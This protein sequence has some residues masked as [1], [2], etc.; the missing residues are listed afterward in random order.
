MESGVWVGAG[1]VCVWVCGWKG[2][3]ANCFPP[4][5]SETVPWLPG[6]RR[7][8]PR[9]TR[10]MFLATP[11]YHQVLHMETVECA[12]PGLLWSFPRHSTPTGRGGSIED[13]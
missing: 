1:C 5:D 8:V 2:G 4:G 3:W 13:E 12:V 6:Q 11:R 7:S 9:S 10:S